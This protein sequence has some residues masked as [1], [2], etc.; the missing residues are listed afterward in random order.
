MADPTQALAQ[1]IEFIKAIDGL[2]N[3]QRK[4]Y[5]FS[6]QRYE[7]SAE[8]SWAVSTFALTLADYAPPKTDINKVI[9]MLLLHDIVEVDAGDSLCYDD[10]AN[11]TKADREQAAAQR[12]FSILPDSQARHFRQLWDEFEAEESTEAQFAAALD[13]MIPMLHNLHT[14]GR[15]WL[16]NHVTLQ[17]VLDK[18]QHKISRAN[19]T[20]WNYLEPQLLKAKSLGWLA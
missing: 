1:R 9:H 10:E 16:E 20:L 15:A 8:H 6:G 12:L 2:K 13:R 3:V 18:N 14:H 11:A 4:T 7:N 19:P 5:L 17:Q